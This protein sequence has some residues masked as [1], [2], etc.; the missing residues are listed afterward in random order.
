[1]PEDEAEDGTQAPLRAVDVIRGAVKAGLLL[2]I[3]RVVSTYSMAW[4]LGSMEEGEQ[5]G[6]ASSLLVFFVLL[7]HKL[8]GTQR[9]GVPLWFAQMIVMLAVFVGICWA[10]GLEIAPSEEKV[11][12]GTPSGGGEL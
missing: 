3:V 5:S 4:L 11:V 7:F 1:M 6:G 8:P 10:I 9:T 12:K 2:V